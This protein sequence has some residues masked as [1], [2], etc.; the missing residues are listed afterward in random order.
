[1]AEAIYPFTTRRDIIP[2]GPLG[3]WAV[4]AAGKILKLQK[5]SCV[6]PLDCGKHE[7]RD[8]RQFWHHDQT[9]HAGR[10]Q[11]TAWWP[12]PG[13]IGIYLRSKRIR[14]SVGF[15]RF[16]ATVLMP[17]RYLENSEDPTPSSTRGYP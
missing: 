2:Q 16:W 8:P 17:T 11:K 7:R 12:P 6:M 3:L 9:L 1:M 4:A 14:K 5:R 15:S 10:R 13:P